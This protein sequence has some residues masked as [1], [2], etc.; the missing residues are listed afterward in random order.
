MAAG[1]RRPDTAYGQLPTN[2]RV[3]D[4]WKVLD[5]VTLQ[6]KI[7]AP[8]HW[9]ENGGNNATHLVWMVCLLDGDTRLVQ[10]TTVTENAD[11][12][13]STPQAPPAALIRYGVVGNAAKYW[14]GFIDHDNW[15]QVP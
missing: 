12:T 10:D 4:Y 5:P 3:G 7:A 6:P 15:V 2:P 13:V 11:N 14:Q 9:T 1:R 8:Q